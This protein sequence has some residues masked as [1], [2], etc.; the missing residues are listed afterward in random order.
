MDSRFEE[1]TPHVVRGNSFEAP[2]PGGSGGRVLKAQGLKPGFN[3][4]FKVTIHVDPVKGPLLILDVGAAAWST[5]PSFRS[6]RKLDMPRR[7]RRGSK[8]AF[9]TMFFTAVSLKALAEAAATASEMAPK[10]FE[11]RS[12]HPSDVVTILQFTMGK[13]KDMLKKFLSGEAN[14]GVSE[15]AVRNLALSTQQRA[16]SL[17]LVTSTAVAVATTT[18]TG[19][20]SSSSKPH[21]FTSPPNKID[22]ISY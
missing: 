3:R 19:A 9:R 2:A 20:T 6:A 22:P 12:F 11:L 14:S 18:P 4:N 16:R 5:L 15:A 21:H 17:L 10:D 8:E 13:L 1:M 7:R